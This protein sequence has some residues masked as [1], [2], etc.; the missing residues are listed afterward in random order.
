MGAV[1]L[2]HRFIYGIPGVTGGRKCKDRGMLRL[3]RPRLFQPN[4]AH[5][6]DL[7]SKWYLL[8]R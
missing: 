4:L 3:E 2:P 1:P 5:S 8:P 6:L 7:L